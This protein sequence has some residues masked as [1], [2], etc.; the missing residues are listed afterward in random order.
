MFTCV[1]VS[2]LRLGVSEYAWPTSCTPTLCDTP[3]QEQQYYLPGHFNQVKVVVSGSVV[4]YY[5]LIV[6]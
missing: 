6:P 4:G 2:Y 3:E 5:Q 1:Y